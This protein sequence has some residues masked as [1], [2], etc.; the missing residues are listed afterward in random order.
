MTAPVIRVRGLRKRLGPA[1]VLAGVSLEVQEREIFVI[2]G[3][4]GTGKTVLLRHLIGL[5]RPDAGEIYLWDA[6]L[7]ALEGEALDALRLRMG[8]VFQGAALFDSMTVAENIAFP[9]RRHRSESETMIRE[10]VA[11]LLELVGLPGAGE[12]MPA[13][14]SGGMRK[15]VGI[16]R[17]LALNPDLVFYDEPTAGLDPPAAREVE[18]L[19][20]RLRNDLAVTSVVVTHDLWTAFGIGDRVGVLM[21]G[22]LLAVGT[23][24][25]VMADPRPE[26]RSFIHPPPVGNREVV[27][28]EP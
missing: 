23:P 10:T 16:A 4:S 11:T 9:V 17:A 21:D 19:I 14:L 18:S 5:L 3:P 28:D 1:E 8:V 20:W 7:H 25:D 6:P 2:M 12:K 22:R 13:T 24:R 26:I 27:R 15:R